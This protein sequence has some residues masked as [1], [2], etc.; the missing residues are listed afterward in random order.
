MRVTRGIDAADRDRMG[1]LVLARMKTLEES[2]A[3]VIKEMRDLKNTST[4]PTRWNSSGEDHKGRTGPS[5]V[6]RFKG[7]FT[8]GK[9]YSDRI[10]VSR[11][12]LREI[13][14]SGRQEGWGGKDKGKGVAYSSDEGGDDDGFSKRAG[15][16]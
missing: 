11:R 14:F 10:P 6:K 16:F 7:T 3:D 8:P 5:E 4:P 2:F 12:S 9:A 1:R 13:K 15:S